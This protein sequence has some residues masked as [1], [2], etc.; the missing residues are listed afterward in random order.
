MGIV[1]SEV[2]LK[3][4]LISLHAGRGYWLFLL[5]WLAAFLA[6]LWFVMDWSLY[7]TDMFNL[8]RVE[9]VLWVLLRSLL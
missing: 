5:L 6:G 2:V 9:F 8:Y 1:K 7:V 3:L 4:I